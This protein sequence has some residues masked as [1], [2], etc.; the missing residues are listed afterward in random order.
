MLGD[1]RDEEPIFLLGTGRCGSTFQQTQLSSFGNVWIWGEHDGIL[2]K[3]MEWSKSVRSS[4]KL[5][6]F[7]FLRPSGDPVAWLQK[8][9]GGN[10][11]M[12]AWLNGF[13]T[14]DMDRV[15]R[16][17]LTNLFTCDLPAGKRRWGFKEIRYGPD[18]RVAEVLLDLFPRAKIVHTLRDP[19][20]TIE[21]G[22]FAWEFPRLQEAFG[23][24]DEALIDSLYGGYAIHWERTTR[25]FLD[26]EATYPDRVRT[27]KL[28]TFH[29]NLPT[30]LTFLKLDASSN[31]ER[32]VLPAVL[33]AS[34]RGGH[35]YKLLASSLK[36]KRM[37]VADVVGA[38]A[39]RAGYDVA[40]PGS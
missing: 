28:E 32:I 14:A 26:L 38:T 10:A 22:L 36:G 17:A 2:T 35:D 25:Y 5:N 8:G 13:R 3:L 15:L 19:F 7:S 21:S 24:G 12:V 31:Q 23:R 39:A 27:S 16:L 29:K 11:T 30:L 18:D 6:E 20:S 34:F 40:V 9:Q 33:N 4:K 37:G 1:A